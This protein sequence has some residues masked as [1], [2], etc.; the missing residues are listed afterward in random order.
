MK[1]TDPKC[2]ETNKAPAR[3]LAAMDGDKQREIARSGGRAA[4]ATGSAHEF[5]SEEARRAGRK[6]GRS[7]SSDRE[8]M[9]RIGRRGG[10]ARQAA[11]KARADENG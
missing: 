4:H 9:A 8:Y 10:Q 5:D 7:V 2:K 6:G 11:R 3:G 1:H